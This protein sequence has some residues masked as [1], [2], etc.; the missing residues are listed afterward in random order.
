MASG[1]A[2]HRRVAV[3]WLPYI[4]AFEADPKAATLDLFAQV[5]SLEEIQQRMQADIDKE[6]QRHEALY[7]LYWALA[8]KVYT[9]TRW[10]RVTDW[11]RRRWRSLFAR[12]RYQ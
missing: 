10:E 4:E 12:R 11:F 3:H 1:S 2:N 9:P 6:E 8:D 5:S 7:A